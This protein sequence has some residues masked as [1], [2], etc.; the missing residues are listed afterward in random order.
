M[1]RKC[2]VAGIN[3]RNEFLYLIGYILVGGIHQYQ[4]TM[5]MQ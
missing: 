5:C 1:F 4:Y 3:F 2:I